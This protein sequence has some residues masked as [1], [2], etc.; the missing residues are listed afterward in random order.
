MNYC[1]EKSEITGNTWLWEVKSGKC[2]ALAIKLWDH[3]R[4]DNLHGTNWLNGLPP[5]TTPIT[6]DEAFLLLL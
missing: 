6:R 5:K 4:W 2:R 3:E 1:L